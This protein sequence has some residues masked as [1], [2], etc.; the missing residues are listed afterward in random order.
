MPNAICLICNREMVKGGGCDDYTLVEA[1]GKKHKRVP[2]AE[3]IDHCGDC[4]AGSGNIHH[5]GCDQERCP[6]CGGQLIS[7][8]CK[9]E[10]VI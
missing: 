6:A 1:N 9:L 3:G 7:C 2:V 4:N 10:I 8:R 5:E